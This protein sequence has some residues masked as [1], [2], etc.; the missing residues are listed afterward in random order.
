MR[1]PTK[2]KAFERYQESLAKG[3]PGITKGTLDSIRAFERSPP[4][5]VVGSAAVMD[6]CASLASTLGGLSAAGGPPGALI[7]A[8]FSMVSMILGFFA[9]KPPSLISQIEEMMR[10][11]QGETVASNI[12]SAKDAVF[13]YMDVCDQY[14]KR[15]DGRVQEPNKLA[16][17]VNALDLISGDE[18]R[19]IRDVRHWLELQANQ[20]LEGW[21]EI[22]NLLCQVYMYLMMALTQQNLYANDEKIIKE[23]LG[24]PPVPSREQA[25]GLLQEATKDKL[26]KLAANNKQQLDFLKLMLPVARTRGTFIVAFQN[27]VVYAATGAKALRTGT[28]GN[29]I[30][31]HCSRV[32]VVP[33]REGIDHPNATYDIWV[34]NSQPQYRY[35]YHGKLAVRTRTVKHPTDIVGGPGTGRGWFD[36]WPLPAAGETFTIYATRYLE[37]GGAFGVYTWIPTDPARLHW[38]NWVP[39]T[40]RIMRYIRVAVPSATPLPGDP[41]GPPA[42]A[43]LN[44]EQICYTMQEG[45]S[46]IY[47]WQN[48]TGVGLVPG[49]MA[50]YRSI[51]VDPYCV[52]VYGDEGVAVA[53]HASIAAFFQ[54]KRATPNWM[55]PPRNN[56]RSV[57]DL[58]VCGDGTLTL[59]DPEGLFSGIY[60]ID[61]TKPDPRDKLAVEWEKWSDLQGAS[62]VQK[63]PVLGWPLLETSIQSLTKPATE[64]VSHTF[65]PN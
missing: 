9:P 57:A 48:G 6:I 3:L 19:T 33:S 12:R 29:P 4:D 31:N 46:E 53:T 38:L 27:S 37:D 16:S 21:P 52:W 50:S 17:V 40:P 18:I 30:F 63:L 1:R 47:V 44:G 5:V 11:L 45:S 60:Q 51:T 59:Y 49:P 65:L 55:G 22:L 25:W 26:V 14:M 41:D 8:M 64:L 61:F 34:L 62:Q 39:W 7:G 15:I 24:D 42:P 32:S 36:W 20:D 23:Y 2:K 35:A 58:S 10:D 54:K 13:V 56:R 43:L 28:W